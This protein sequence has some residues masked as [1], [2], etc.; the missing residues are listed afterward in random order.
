MK[1]PASVLKIVNASPVDAHLCF[2]EI[3]GTIR[4]EPCLRLFAYKHTKTYGKQVKEVGRRFVDRDMLTGSLYYTHLGGYQVV[5]QKQKRVGYYTITADDRF[6]EVT[7]K[8]D[9]CYPKRYFNRLYTAKEVTEKFKGTDEWLNYLYVPELSDIEDTMAYIRAYREHPSLEMLAKSGYGYLWDSKQIYRL[10]YEKHRAVMKFLKNNREY[11]LKHKPNLGWILKAINM[12]MSAA[13]YDE[14]LQTSTLTYWFEGDGYKFSSE[15]IHEIYKYVLKQ[16]SEIDIY[17]DYLS[18]C[19][20]LGSNVHDRG[21]LFPKNLLEKHDAVTQM[22]DEKKHK[23]VNEGLKKAYSILKAF[24]ENTG[25][26]QLVLP[27]SQHD[28]VQ[29]GNKLHMCVGTM[30]YGEKMSKGNTIILGVFLQGQIVECCQIGLSEYDQEDKEMKVLQLR[31]DH[32]TD[33]PYHNECKALTNQFL[34]N[35]KPQNLMGAVI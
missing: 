32:N 25:E 2:V 1:I 14:L 6:Y 21:I 26:F 20:E 3:L 15:L 13:Q 29:W 10:G 18:T 5:F 30:G 19:K 22:L 17:R 27:K 34:M 12:G 11:L 23:E 16:G 7:D 28:L 8:S 24:I 31:G 35:Y 9:M 4:K 33:S